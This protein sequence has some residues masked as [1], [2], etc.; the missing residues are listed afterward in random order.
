MNRRVEIISTVA[1]RRRWAIEEQVAPPRRGVGPGRLDHGGGG[2]ARCQ[3]QPH[4]PVAPTGPRGFDARRDSAQ[5]RPVALRCRAGCGQ[6]RQSASTARRTAPA[7]GG[8]RRSGLIEIA[9]AN[10]RVVKVE[11]SIDPVTL[12]RLIAAL[13]GDAP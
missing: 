4:L 13:D 7:P 5:W 10:G 11:E 9:L 6:R 2:S 1:R 12:A 8:R 3:P